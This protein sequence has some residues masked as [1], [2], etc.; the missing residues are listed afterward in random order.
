MAKTQR[1][2]LRCKA[3]CRSLVPIQEKHLEMVKVDGEKTY[4][5]SFPTR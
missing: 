5:E 2:V 4:R 3:A 1:P